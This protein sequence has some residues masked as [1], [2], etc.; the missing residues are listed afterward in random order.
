MTKEQAVV[1]YFS[2]ELHENR[3]VSDRTF[4]I[5]RECFGEQGVV[6]LAA[7]I[8]YYTMLAMV[9]NVARTDPGASEVPALERF[10]T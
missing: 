2:S 1:W 6:E 4:A 8:G 9:M 10:P 7:F 3:S 5:A